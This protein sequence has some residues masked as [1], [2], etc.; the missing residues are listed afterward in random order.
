[1]LQ[2]LCGLCTYIARVKAARTEHARPACALHCHRHAEREPL[3][4]PVRDRSRDLQT[5][6]SRIS[7]HT[8]HR[9]AYGACCSPEGSHSTLLR[10]RAGVRRRRAEAAAQ[11]CN[12]CNMHHTTCKVRLN[13]AAGIMQHATHILRAAME[14]PAHRKRQ[15][16]HADA[17]GVTYARRSEQQPATRNT[18]HATCSLRHATCNVQGS[19]SDIRHPNAT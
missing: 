1:M 13:T 10:D 8:T 19:T 12:A 18:Q 6:Y 11:G 3:H 14:G 16:Q 9:S 17:D 5:G 2:G 15:Q 7:A 4:R